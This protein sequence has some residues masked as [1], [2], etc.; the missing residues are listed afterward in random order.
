MSATA[1]F[2]AF[3][4][5]PLTVGSFTIKNRLVVGTGKYRDYE[6][7]QRALDASGCDAVTVAVRRERLVD[8]QGR[9]L[10]DH[11]DL[12]RYTILPNTAGCFSADDAVREYSRC[13][14]YIRTLAGPADG[15]CN[16]QGICIAYGKVW[17]M[18]L[19]D[20]AFESGTTGRNAIWSMNY[21]GTGLQEVCASS[22]FGKTWSMFPYNGGFLVSDIQDSNLEFAPLDCAASAPFYAFGQG[23]VSMQSPQQISTLADGT[24]V[25]QFFS[26]NA[27]IAFFSPTGELQGLYIYRRRGQQ[28]IGRQFVD[29]VHALGV[30]LGNGLGV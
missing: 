1:Q 24:V 14:Q 20:A 5:P 19:F 22:T 26:G 8:A 30:G 28:P 25:A 12:A 7:M 4:I 15:V 17:F 2:P 18:R 6:T 21:D 13:G 9:S 3:A 16:P 29:R 23:G 10:L 11:L 27:G